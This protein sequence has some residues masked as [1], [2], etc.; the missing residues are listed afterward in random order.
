MKKIFPY[1]NLLILSLLLPVPI[2]RYHTYDEIQTKLEAWNQEYGQD[3]GN[4]DIIYQLT[5]IGRSALLDLP[6]WMVKISDNAIEDEDEPRILILGQCH[7][8]EILGVELSMQLIE[9]LLDPSSD[10]CYSNSMKSYVNSFLSNTEIY[11]VP[12]HNPEGLS[13]V[14]GTLYNDDYIQDS[15]FRKNMTDANGNGVFDYDASVQAGGDLD[16]VDLN[17]NYDFNWGFGD[18][19]GVPDY[20]SC[21]SSYTS[22]FDYYKGSSAGSESETDAITKLA[23]EKQF[24][25]SVAYHSSR[26]GCVSEKVIYPWL[27]EDNKPSPDFDVIEKL[28]QEIAA[29]IPKE[30]ENN[31]YEA[32]NSVSRKGN[33]HDWFY[34]TTGTFQYLIELGTSNLQP[35]DPELID[36]TIERNFRGLFYLISRAYGRSQGN[37]GVDE[38]YIVQGLVKSG[39]DIVP[40]AV[41]SIEELSGGVL[42]PRT[43]DKFGRYRRLLNPGSYTLITSAFGYQSDTTTFT[44]SSN[45]NEIDIEL[46]QLDSFPITVSSTRYPADLR[47][48]S[49]AW[50]TSLVIAQPVEIVLPEGEYRLEAT[51]DDGFPYISE[52][53]HKGSRVE[54]ISI[55]S[56]ETVY[57]ADFSDNSFFGITTG[58]CGFEW[59]VAEGKLHSPV[60][61]ST[62]QYPDN[63]LSGFTLQTAF[64]SYDG[65]N[66]DHVLEI[67]MS[68]ELEWDNDM[69]SVVF[70]DIATLTGGGDLLDPI[71]I[72][73]HGDVSSGIFRMWEDSGAILPQ[74][75]QFFLQLRIDSDDSVA[76]GGVEI[77]S[78]KVYSKESEVL[79]SSEHL[80]PAPT[81]INNVI[82]YPNPFNAVTNLSFDLTAPSNIDINVY[83]INGKHIKNIISSQLMAP[84][85]YTVTIDMDG[86]STGLYFIEISNE[87]STLTK[88]ILYLK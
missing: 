86:Y 9:C 26:S 25:L 45:G 84:N 11:I 22:D 42:D 13:V 60:N 35:D 44:A 48:R 76:Y 12:T 36:D 34:K 50:D 78:I 1:I 75:S 17:R 3:S 80:Y 65:T 23:I 77:E 71:E 6:F 47:L 61:P 88:Q 21:N 66:K 37:Y 70:T 38:N 53:V 69:V 32:R 54:N 30:V 20:G 19:F 72:S 56:R 64:F 14:H 82:A 57:E 46:V 7:A 24:L 43:T 85:P 15:S 74:P 5:E 33:A 40:G 83:D 68:H 59:T 4:S 52:F 41:V 67:T 49:A 73:G 55:Y 31:S 62:G 29:L 79:S 87:Q 63:C 27:W 8:E 58:S 10:T 2:D 81:A 18:E 39:G 51:A 16:G 28:G